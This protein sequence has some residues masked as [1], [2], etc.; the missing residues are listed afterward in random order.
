MTAATISTPIPQFFDTTGAPLTGGRVYFGTVGGNPETAPITVYWDSDLTQPAAQPVQTLGGY[1][2]RAGT[3]AQ[4]YAPSDYSVT[5]KDKRGRQVLYSRDSAG[6][7]FALAST[8]TGKGASLVGMESAGTVQQFASGFTNAA[9]WTGVDPSGATSSRAGFAAINSYMTTK[10]G[11]VVFLSPGTYL[12]DPTS[13]AQSLACTVPI[14]WYGTEGVTIKCSYYDLAAIS[15]VGCNGG[16]CKGI[17]F[18]FSGTRPGSTAGLT[19][20]HFG[21]NSTGVDSPSNFSAFISLLGCHNVWIDECTFA[22][23]TTGNIKESAIQMS[24]GTAT[25]PSLDGGTIMVPGANAVYSAGNKVTNC[26][27]NDV[28]FGIAG[29]AQENATVENIYSRRY[30]NAGF[31]GAGHVVYMTGSW[32]YSRI[33]GIT[34]YGENL[35]TV[36][37]SA[38]NTA[39]FRSPVHCV[40]GGI[41]SARKEG[42][43]G[44]VNNVQ[45]NVFQDIYWSADRTADEAAMLNTAVYTFGTDANGGTFTR[46]TFRNVVCVDITN[47][48]L[49]RSANCPIMS[50]PT[51]NTSSSVTDNDFDITLIFA[52]DASNSRAHFIGN[53]QRNKYKFTLTNNGTGTAKN[54][55]QL[56]G[57]AAGLLDKN[58]VHFSLKGTVTTYDVSL[59]NSNGTNDIYVHGTGQINNRAVATGLATGDR[60]IPDASMYSVRSD[61]TASIFAKTYIQSLTGNVTVGTPGN[62]YVGAT[63][64]FTFNATGVFTVAWPASFRAAANGAAAANKSASTRFICTDA[65]TP[66]WVQQGGA[67]TYN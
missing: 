31:V 48:G 52:P 32:R 60:L 54:L 21:F 38:C 55:L 66:I 67:L 8:A 16:G 44:A 49:G 62:P 25:G 30:K 53:G 20:S 24:G 19:S 29:F 47:A 56:I 2:A 17:N 59:T 46:N 58:E 40:I 3:P 50:N 1:P 18:V 64:D 10:G 9:Q 22:G 39:V 33:Y 65:A 35:D 15:F 4:L 28:Y 61:L 6:I 43:I 37:S 57:S 51:G 7:T 5:V 36:T 34:D 42:C 13:E 41:N 26:T 27:F 45:D 63:L 14:L 23:L 11:G 12:L